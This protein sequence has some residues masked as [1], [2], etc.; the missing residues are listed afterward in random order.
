MKKDH[1]NRLLEMK[2]GEGKSC[3][4]A[5]FA[6]VLCMQEKKVDIVTSSPILAVRDVEEWADFYSIFNYTVTHNT[7]LERETDANMDDV[8]REYY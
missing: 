4:V 6:T 7:D 8:K 5:L 3:L 2:T 1:S